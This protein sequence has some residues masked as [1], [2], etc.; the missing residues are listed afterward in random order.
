MRRT[1]H[2]SVSERGTERETGGRA[3]AVAPTRVVADGIH[4]VRIRLE[5][6]LVQLLRLPA[7]PNA[8]THVCACTSSSKEKWRRGG[9][10]AGGDGEKE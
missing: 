10:G 1:R 2:H 5:R 7:P 6:A 4:V 8:F 3:R 9:G